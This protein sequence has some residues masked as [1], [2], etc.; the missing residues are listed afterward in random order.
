[1]EICGNCIDDN[2]DGLTD[3]E[4][5]ACC[6]TAHK[7][8]TARSKV[9]IVPGTGTSRFRLRSLLA[10]A[11]L[12]SVDPTKQGVVLQIRARDARTDLFCAQVP[13]ERFVAKRRRFRFRDPE[14]TVDSARG[15]SAMVLRIGN[16]GSVRFTA[17]GK[18]VK[19]ASPKAGP[20]QLTVGF[21]SPTADNVANRC[22]TIIQGFRSTRRGGLRAP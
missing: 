1:V 18:Q 21:R 8:P 5:P 7:Y 13:P 9:R 14:L 11:G 12:A 20:F 19:L 3:F 15:L 22:S 6:I 17:R 2:G 4:D 10:R 16:D